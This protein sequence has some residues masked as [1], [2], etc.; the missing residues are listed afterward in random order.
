MWLLPIS[1]EMLGIKDRRISIVPFPSPNLLQDRCPWVFVATSIMKGELAAVCFAKT[2]PF[3]EDNSLT[4]LKLKEYVICSSLNQNDTLGKFFE[5]FSP[6]EFLDYYRTDHLTHLIYLAHEKQRVYGNAYPFGRLELT[7]NGL[8][9]DLL[10]TFGITPQPD[11]AFRVI[12]YS[13]EDYEFLNPTTGR[14]RGLSALLGDTGKHHLI[15]IETFKTLAPNLW[16]KVLSESVDIFEDPSELLRR[17]VWVM[18]TFL[19]RFLAPV[20]PEKSEKSNDPGF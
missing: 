3:I 11:R 18:Q 19:S 9:K 6:Q 1:K 17:K 2:A 14:K 4:L 16:M 15:N 10:N 7:D 5:S 20:I 8:T 13:N 12:C